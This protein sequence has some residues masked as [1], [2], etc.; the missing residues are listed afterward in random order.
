MRR[1]NRLLPFLAFILL[2]A[3]VGLN[4]VLYARG[5]QYYRELNETRL[6]PLGLNVYP[7]NSQPGQR[8]VVVFLGD[9]RAANWPPPVDGFSFVNRG[10]GAQTS[11]QVAGR[12]ARHVAPLTPDIVIVQVCINDL[13]TIPLFLERETA[14]ID[15]CKAN[16]ARIVDDSL[17]LGAAVI[18]TTVFPVGSV[19]LERR[20]FWSDR[21]AVAV[22]DVN[23]YILSLRGP[24]V[25][26]LDTYAILA[27]D[28]G[29]LRADYSV[30]MLHLNAAGYA[31][32]NAALADILKQLS[33]NRP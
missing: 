1:L 20:L 8:P 7:E 24:R 17:E 2:L 26:V 18:L 31:A 3:S 4:V 14:I 9:S 10:I 23:R 32:L 6:D 19:P 29:R 27:D 5:E 12:F 25:A 28:S 33:I 15:G 11:A 30:D 22:E 13:K 16:L 21:V